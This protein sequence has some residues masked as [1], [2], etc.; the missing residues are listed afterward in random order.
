MSC[1]YEYENTADHSVS[2]KLQSLSVGFLFY[3]CVC[4][5]YV[6]FLGTSDTGYD[7]IFMLDGTVNNRV[8]N[9]MKNFVR[10]YASQLPIDSGEYRVGAMTYANR[11]NGQFQLNQYNFQDE[12]SIMT[13]LGLLFIQRPWNEWLGGV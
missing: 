10:N 11:P 1:N 12:V 13:F 3:C 9:W 4:L 7:L 8:F 6:L 5:G 2:H